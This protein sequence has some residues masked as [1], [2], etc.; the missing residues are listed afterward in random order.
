MTDLGLQSSHFFIITIFSHSGYL[1][2]PG[3]TETRHRV[4]KQRLHSS[5]P[6]AFPPRVKKMGAVPATLAVKMGLF[7][8]FLIAA[9][10]TGVR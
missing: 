5:E 8:D 10:L 1:S 9:I 2:V 4:T 3:P 7:V 6:P